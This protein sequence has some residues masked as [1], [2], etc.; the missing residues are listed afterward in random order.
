MDGQSALVYPGLLFTHCAYL[1]HAAKLCGISNPEVNS[2][3]LDNTAASLE[4]RA[5]QAHCFWRL[6]GESSCAGACWD[7]HS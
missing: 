7:S 4:R 6:V 5:M 1:G 3:Y 2:L